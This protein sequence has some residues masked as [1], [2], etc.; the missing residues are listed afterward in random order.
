MYFAKV[1]IIRMYT[2]YNVFSYSAYSHQYKVIIFARSCIRN[3]NI[4]G[5][6]VER[7]MT[8]KNKFRKPNSFVDTHNYYNR[9]YRR[10]LSAVMPDAV[11][12]TNNH[13]DSID[14]QLYTHNIPRLLSNLS[15]Q[16]IKLIN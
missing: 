8:N 11:P 5:E 9:L 14:Y 16:I 1:I 2:S 3:L 12:F 10:K 13:I 6:T 15:C 7:Y 4:T